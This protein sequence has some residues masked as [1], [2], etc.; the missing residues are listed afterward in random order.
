ML[1]SRISI[2]VPGTLE[3]NRSV[4][5]SSGWTRI[6]RALWRRAPRSRSRERLVRRPL[7]HDRDLGDP[8]AEPLAGAQVERHAG[9]AT[10]VDVQ[11]DRG[12]RLGRR[13]LADAVLVEEARGPCSPPAQPA[14]YWPRAVVRSSRCGSA[15]LAST[16]CF[17][18]RRVSASKSAAPPSRPAPSAGAGGSGSRRG[19]RRCRRSSRPGR[20]C[21]T[22]S[23]IV[24]CT[25]ST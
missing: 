4:M 5:P 12:V 14:A 2:A 6:T 24:I 15:T 9:P 22:S 18:M 17:S 11:L 13:G 7:E 25:W 8:A 1:T 10:G 19:R 23:A 3:P 16:F 20:R 21:R